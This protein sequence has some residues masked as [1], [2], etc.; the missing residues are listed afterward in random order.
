MSLTFSN[1]MLLGYYI[2]TWSTVLDLLLSLTVES[3]HIL[4]MFSYNWWQTICQ[5]KKAPVLP[6]IVLSFLQMLLCYIAISK[7]SGGTT[8]PLFLSSSIHPATV[9]IKITKGHVEHFVK[10]IIG[11]TVTK[12]TPPTHFYTSCLHFPPGYFKCIMVK[13][14]LDWPVKCA[15]L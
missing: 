7:A 10:A 1:A 14:T 12:G 6:S 13:E 11:Y 15:F 4:F 2:V 8:I 3:W 5:D 9:A